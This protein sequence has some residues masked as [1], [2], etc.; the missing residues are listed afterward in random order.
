MDDELLKAYDQELGQLR[1]AGE[2]F[3]RAHPKIAGRLRLGPDQLEDPHVSRLVES[4]AFLNAR[5]RRKLDDDFPELTD[6]ILGVL[7]PYFLAPIPSMSI[8]QF[9]CAPD[10]T[11]PVVVERGTSLV[12]DSTYGEPCR[13]RTAYETEVHPIRVAGA[14]LSGPP[15]DAPSTPRSGS[16]G[17][18]LHVELRSA[19]E[20]VSI[21]SLA[22]ER[23]RFFLHGEFRHAVRLYELLL[24]DLVE[25]AVAATTKERGPTVLPAEAVRPVGFEVGEEVLPDGTRSHPEYRMLCEYFAFPQK[26]LFVDLEG[27]DLSKYGE[28]VHLFFYLRRTEKDLEPLVRPETFRLGC[29]PV[30]NL[31]ER[32]AE[33]VR[34]DGTRA[35]YHLVADARHELETEIYSIDTVHASSRETGRREFQPFYGLDHSLDADGAALYW[36]AVRRETP[37][38]ED[39]ID[40]GTEM[41]VSIVDGSGDPGGP[42]EGILE[43]RVTCLNR[44]QPS[45]LPFGGGHPRV[46]FAKGGGAITS[47]ECLTPPTQ[48]VRPR[49]GRGALWRLV[50]ML[51]LHH[52]SLAGDESSVQHLRECLRLFESVA[53]S[54]T[55]SAPE[56]IVAVT[57]RPSVGRVVVDGQPGFCRGL[58]VS[59]VLDEDRLRATGVFLF[60]TVLERFFAG[61]CTINSFVR[62]VAS[63]SVRGKVLRRWPPRSGS[64][65]LL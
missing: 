14:S 22:P 60:A 25:V 2:R 12:T 46:S 9:E 41:F 15:F 23:L 32:D 39:K 28:V 55:R 40:R 34:L 65:I 5:I 1:R 53:A 3:A 42:S 58:E 59:V 50:S 7:S 47:I 20:S 18:V 43:S 24:N 31:F 35:E 27:L 26:F 11:A 62:T 6:S 64:R 57:G 45:K 44:N 36:H 61:L 29:T 10:L 17:G 51:A 48:T 38:G 8:V 4:V 21:G 56:S 16:C 13:Y 33:P 19:D 54:E 30:V 63:T 37:R 52:N 49:R